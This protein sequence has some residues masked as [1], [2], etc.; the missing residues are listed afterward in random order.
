MK[1]SS[2]ALKILFLLVFTN[3][4]LF[5]QNNAKKHALIIAI[6]K[7]PEQSGWSKISSSNDIPFVKKSLERQGFKSNDIQVIENNKATKVSIVNA[8]ENLIKDSSVKSGD[9]IFI[10]VSS[11]GVQILDDNGDESDNL[12]E[13]IVPFDAVYDSIEFEN[14]KGNYLRDDEFGN[15]INRLRLKLGSKGDVIVTMDNCHSGSGTRG[16]GIKRG[17]KEPL[18]PVGYGLKQTTLS[19]K[20]TF[21]DN[22]NLVNEKKQLAGYIV[23][24]AS[25]DDQVDVEINDDNGN[26]VGP[27]SYA[28]SKAF[29]QL[30]KSSTYRT[31]F[32][33]IEVI[34]NEKVPGQQPQIDGT[35]I[36]RSLFAGDY[37]YQKPYLEITEAK[38]SILTLKGGIFAGLDEGALLDIYPSGTVTP[39][40]QK[41]IA[42][43]RV[44][45]SDN[46]TCKII[47]DNNKTINNPLKFWAF[48]TAPVFKLEPL[49]IKILSNQTRG[50]ST[51][52]YFTTEET[53]QIKSS[54][55]NNQLVKFDETNPDL[56]LIKG[57]QNSDSI[58]I[59]KT[60][61]LFRIIDVSKK[62]DEGNLVVQNDLN[63]AITDYARYKL[64]H[65][66][67]KNDAIKFDVELIPFKGN[68]PNLDLYNSML[69]KGKLQFKGDGTDSVVVRVSNKSRETIYFNIMDMM[70]DGVVASFLPD[71][72]IAIDQLKL[73]PGQTRDYKV[74]SFE[75]PYGQEIFKVFASTKPIDMSMI[76]SSDAKKLNRERSKGFSN[77]FES[78]F[79]NGIN[80][81]GSKKGISIEKSAALNVTFEIIE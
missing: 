43:A 74:T 77:S 42:T 49:S 51:N 28:I 61:F 47:L 20:I 6:G 4:L 18:I 40:V 41:R 78:A 70:P 80:Q 54:L 34:M 1:Y 12:D 57:K 63:D 30:D 21:S 33:K 55:S 50:F 32:S 52:N 46:Y 10:H 25:K 60:G 75:P 16:V 29:E 38:D 36:D 5:G 19:Q 71:N 35:G 15:M 68:K 13:A 23:I 73:N 48:V 26:S 69:K 14:V 79:D 76:V 8:L 37:I 66:E 72:E 59:A 81:R 62:S 64:L 17:G 39:E 2:Y 22:V 9:V 31:L 67:I 24:A 3:N 53:N 11:H 58:F 56:I 7:Y 65:K 44:I 27:L 45:N